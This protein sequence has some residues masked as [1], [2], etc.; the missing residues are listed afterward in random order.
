M[1]EGM[2]D[3]SEFLNHLAFIIAAREIGLESDSVHFIPTIDTPK[4]DVAK[5]VAEWEA[6]DSGIGMRFLNR[7]SEINLKSFDESDAILKGW[8]KRMS[9]RLIWNEMIF[10]T[11]LLV[12]G[13]ILMDIMWMVETGIHTIR[14]Q[15]VP[16]VFLPIPFVIDFIAKRVKRKDGTLFLVSQDDAEIRRIMNDARE[17]FLMGRERVIAGKM[18]GSGKSLIA[19]EGATLH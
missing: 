1:N 10:G 18:D 13:S 9:H 19:P 15:I 8:D 4:M 6:D 5:M 2:E 7:L 16:A 11:T 17:E 12:V 3:R 14:E